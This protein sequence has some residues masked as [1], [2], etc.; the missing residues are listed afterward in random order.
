M[1]DPPL[2][3]EHERNEQEIILQVRQL[4]DTQQQMKNLA[5]SH[6]VIAQQSEPA[7]KLTYQWLKHPKDDHRIPRECLQGRVS[8]LEQL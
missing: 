4:A 1:A 3:E 2:T 7:I 5:D 8:Q 6:W